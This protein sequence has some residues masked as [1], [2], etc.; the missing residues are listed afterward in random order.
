[1]RCTEGVNSAERQQP[2]AVMRAV[3]GTD[4]PYAAAQSLIMKIWISG[5]A[6]NVREIMNTVQT[7]YL[8]ISM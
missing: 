7:I 4:V 5:S 6:L 1:M 8:P 2:E 3:Q